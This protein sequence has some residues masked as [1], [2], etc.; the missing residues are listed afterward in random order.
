MKKRV[1]AIA[2]VVL[3]TVGTTAGIADAD[4]PLA[5]EEA[6]TSS[7]TDSGG[8]VQVGSSGGGSGKGGPS[9]PSPYVDCV[10][11]PMV[12]SVPWLAGSQ[13]SENATSLYENFSHEQFGAAE[14]WTSCRLEADPESGATWLNSPGTPGADLLVAHAQ[15]QLDL[16]LPDVGTSPPRGST[17]LVA[18]PVWFWVENFEAQSTTA[19]IPGLAAT[20]TATPV[21]SS[22]RVSGPGRSGADGTDETFSC[23]G[24]GTEWVAGT[25]DAWAKSDCSFSFDWSGT[26]TVEA[27]VA[28][29]LAWTATNGQTGTLPPVQRTT[30]FTMNIEQAQA[31][32]D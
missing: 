23:S 28:W 29:E 16:A 25:N 5:R 22:Y 32:L 1:G 24:G 10:K 19:E 17:Q 20:L 6:A 18:V 12:V 31:A 2:V 15:Q 8:L 30:T 26:W 4:I 13:H 9:R 27:T 14:S 3:V 11:L 7:G 21:S